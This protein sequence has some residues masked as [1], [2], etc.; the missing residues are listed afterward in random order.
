[1]PALSWFSAVIKSRTSSPATL[2]LFLLN[3]LDF[4]VEAP[5]AKSG[6]IGTPETTK[7]VES[8]QGGAMKRLAA[9]LLVALV[10]AAGCGGKGRSREP[11]GQNEPAAAVIPTPD[12]TPIE[13]LRTPAGLVLKA[14]ETPAPVTPSPSPE[15]TPQAK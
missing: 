13:A 6:I 12:T 4:R 7:F 11:H 14:N 3:D 1:M 9:A 10:W 8:K 5:A 2:S 15:P